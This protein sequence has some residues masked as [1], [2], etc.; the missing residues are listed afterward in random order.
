MLDWRGVAEVLD[1]RDRPAVAFLGQHDSAALSVRGR[2]RDGRK[3]AAQIVSAATEQPRRVG[4][5]DFYTLFFRLLVAQ[6][7]EPLGAVGTASGGI[8]HEVG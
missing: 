4:D 5:F 1:Q 2:R 6:A 7:I 8:D 3:V